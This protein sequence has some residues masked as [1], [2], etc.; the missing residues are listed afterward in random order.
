[1]DKKKQLDRQNKWLSENREQ[2]TITLPLGTKARIKATGESVNAFVN[3]LI[4][5]ELERIEPTS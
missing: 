1:M 4:K 5:A 2:Q 3:R